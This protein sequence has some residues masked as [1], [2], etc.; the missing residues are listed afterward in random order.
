MSMSI[1]NFCQARAIKYLLVCLFT[2]RSSIYD[3]M[4]PAGRVRHT[5]YNA[6]DFTKQ[7]K[8]VPIQKNPETRVSL[9]V[10]RK[11]FLQEYR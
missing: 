5:L 10:K 4:Q 9:F 7:Q 3:W 6:V 11:C 1:A 2:S 8:K